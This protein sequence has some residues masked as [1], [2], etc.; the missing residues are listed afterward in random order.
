MFASV[1]P[2]LHHTFLREELELANNGHAPSPFSRSSSVGHE[3]V[4]DDAKR[5]IELDLL[6][7]HVGEIALD[8]TRPVHAVAVGSSTPARARKIYEYEWLSISQLAAERDHRHAAFSSRGNT[9][10]D[11]LVER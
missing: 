1:R 6:D 10:R 4:L 11:R 3:P 9:V 8:A 7:G 5:L 2:D